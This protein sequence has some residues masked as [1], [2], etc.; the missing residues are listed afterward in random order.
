MVGAAFLLALLLFLPGQWTL[1][2]TD[3]DEA[4][5]AQASRQILETGDLIDIRFQ[6][7]AR[8]KK[9]A[10]AYWAQAGTAS[11]AGGA[12]AAIGA[13]RAPSWIAAA[14]AVALT[15]WAGLAL[16]GR[17][18]AMLAGAGLAC[19]ALLAVEAR[20]AKTDALLLL[21][22]VAA[23][24]ALA[25]I[26]S[27]GGD[28]R[29]WALLLWLAVGAGLL[30]KG[31]IILI[32]IA[33]GLAG[34]ALAA[35]SWAPIRAAVPLWGPALA[36]ALAA[37]W[38]IAITLVSDGAFWT[39]SVGRDLLAKAAS[40]QESHGAPPGYHTLVAFAAFWP[41]AILL[42]VAAPLVWRARARPETALL[43][44]WVAATWLVFELVPTKL[45][46]YT[47][48]AYPALALLLAA[49][50]VE[51]LPAPARGWRGAMVA[52]WALPAA[53]LAGAATLGPWA[54]VGAPS[55]GGLALG[56]ATLAAAL[57]AGRALWDWRL[58]VFA[59]AAAVSAALGA[60]AVLHFALPALSVAFPAPA[61]AAETAR[62]RC[63][64]ARPVALTGYREPS[65][66]FHLGTDTLL[67]DGPGAAQAVAEGR[68]GLAWIDA[69]ARDIFLAAYPDAASRAQL[70]AFNYSNG[71]RV[72]LTLYDAREG[73]VCAR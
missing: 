58:A 14:G 55:A 12:E 60:T 24:G 22:C 43:L 28:A 32:P 56:L 51:G 23:L 29:R 50:A 27:G 38:L 71:R 31:P 9:P 4:R 33:G 40:G 36:L 57:V 19:V 26:Q 42:P 11:L 7:T 16:V 49:A 68:A 61:M 72:S 73:G 67:T 10:L 25:R 65:A 41:W 1:P 64:D 53:A 17:P 13:F 34:A 6:E 63:G 44:G 30:I 62:W 3:R 15:F 47:L 52:L 5:F 45:P 70:D 37:P 2:V 21:A 59:P 20:L 69:R 48:P 66:V 35:R 8:H 46:H 18:A 39:E 54:I